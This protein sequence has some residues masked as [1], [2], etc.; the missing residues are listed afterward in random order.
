MSALG[1]M[2]RMM[3]RAGPSDED[4]SQDSAFVDVISNTLMVVLVM[5]LLLVVVSGLRVAGEPMP[6]DAAEVD[7][8][9][10]ERELFP[11]WS[12]YYLVAAQGLIELDLA[13]IV[14][15]LEHDRLTADNQRWRGGFSQ[16]QVLWQDER[17]DFGLRQELGLGLGDLDNFRLQIQP[18]PDQLA[19]DAIGLT[20]TSVDQLINGWKAAYRA[21]REVP[22]FFVYAG[23]MDQFARL[24]PSLQQA[25]LRFRWTALKAREPVVLYRAQS[26][27]TSPMLRF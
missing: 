9:L 23:G 15:L 18:D 25:G 1:S 27:F 21:R 10:P 16:G 6:A 8:R 20:P 7:L 3:R 26:Q 12:R 2:A 14:S 19:K 17:A 5:T 22:G 13:A 4:G 24:F 11:P